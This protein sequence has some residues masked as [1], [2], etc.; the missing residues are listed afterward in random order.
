LFAPTVKVTT[1]IHELATV[2]RLA[3]T[4][5]GLHPGPTVV[6]ADLLRG[7]VPRQTACVHFARAL[8]AEARVVAAVTQTSATGPWQL[9]SSTRGLLR[10]HVVTE[11]VLVRCLDPAS[12]GPPEEA[13][14]V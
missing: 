13:G 9:S 10:D 12:I 6:R 8:D 14:A 3:Q 2:P 7:D 5:D 1:P 11:H 4:A